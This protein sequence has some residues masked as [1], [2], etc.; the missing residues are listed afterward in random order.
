MNILVLEPDYEYLRDTLF[1]NIFGN[2]IMFD[3]FKDALE[4]RKTLVKANQR[5]PTLFTLAGEKISQNAVLDPSGNARLPNHLEY[6]YGEPKVKQ[7][8][9]MQ[10]TYGKYLCIVSYLI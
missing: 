4:Y 9:E 2:A 3:N 8:A 1:Y 5:P 10:A 7:I 6:V